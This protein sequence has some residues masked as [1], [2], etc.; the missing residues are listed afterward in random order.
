MTAFEDFLVQ[1]EN[2]LTV[3]KL[4]E[5][6]KKK[7]KNDSRIGLKDLGRRQLKDVENM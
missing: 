3:F 4:G 7:R 2:E 5:T 6:Q 1:R